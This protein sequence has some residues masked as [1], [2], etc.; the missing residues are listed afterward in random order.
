MKID[1]SQNEHMGVAFAEGS[2]GPEGFYIDSDG[3]PLPVVQA[4]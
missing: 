4:N 1:E 2:E 3:N